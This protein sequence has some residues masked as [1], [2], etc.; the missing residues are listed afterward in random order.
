MEP[1]FRPLMQGDW[2]QPVTTNRRSRWTFKA[3]WS[4]T[5]KLVARELE[6]A[7]AALGLL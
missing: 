6:R 3:Q 1:R 4:D 5:L 7:G 2:G